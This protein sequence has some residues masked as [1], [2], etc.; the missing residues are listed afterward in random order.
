MAVG[1]SREF[2]NISRKIRQI[3]A[4][5]ISLENIRIFVR[6]AESGSFSA[7]GRTLRISPSV[8]SYRLQALETYLNCRLVSRTTRRMNLTEAGR[9]V[10]EARRDVSES[11]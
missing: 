10:S 11:A 7:A 2:R 1:T 5:M 4:L 3:G 8:V 9:G 6:A